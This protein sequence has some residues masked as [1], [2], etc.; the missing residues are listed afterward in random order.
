MCTYNNKSSAVAEMGDR[1]ASIDMGWK[2]GGCCVFFGESWVPIWHN[3]TWTEAYQRTKWHPDPS[4]GLATTDMGRKLGGV[5]P[6]WVS[7]IP[8]NTIQ[9]AY[10]HT[11][12]HLDP[13]KHLTTMHQRC[14]Q[15]RQTDNG[16]I[17]YGTNRFTNGRPKSERTTVSFVE[18]VL[19]GPVV[20]NSQELI[21][22]WDSERELFTTTSYMYR[23]A[24]TPIEP[25][26]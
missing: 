12:W 13:S 16:L 9:E 5:V 15:D 24:P 17:A 2:D 26:S 8:S 21:R 4:R 25:T 3:V 11:K 22:R 18:F 1:L 7:S 14:R 6:L 19:Y 20:V 23:P 10:V